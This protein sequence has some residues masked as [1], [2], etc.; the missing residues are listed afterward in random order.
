V[1]QLAQLVQLEL[2]VQQV[3]LALQVFVVQQVLK[4]TQVLLQ[5]FQDLKEK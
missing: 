5:Q 4:V 3:T 1:D 2:R